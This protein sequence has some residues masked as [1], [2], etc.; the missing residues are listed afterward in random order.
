M[1]KAGAEN[2]ANAYPYSEEWKR[3]IDRNGPEWMAYCEAAELV[4]RYLRTRAEKGNEA[5]TEEI[6]AT[7]QTFRLHSEAH[8]DRLKTDF[9]LIWRHEREAMIAGMRQK[10]LP[11]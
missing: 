11:S 3:R 9:R 4:R 7:Y 1:D 8:A 10:T 2:A 5:A 6:L